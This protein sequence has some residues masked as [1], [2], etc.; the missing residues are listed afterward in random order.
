[1]NTY[2]ALA[3]ACPT[4]DFNAF[5]QRADGPGSNVPCQTQSSIDRFRQIFRSL[6]DAYP[7][8]SAKVREIWA[9][10]A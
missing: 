1:M 7:L 4:Y 5:Q 6:L 2:L 8:Q 10:P 3:S 9:Q